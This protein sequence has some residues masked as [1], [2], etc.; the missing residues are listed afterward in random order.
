MKIW[1]R[2]GVLRKTSTYARTSGRATP[3]R[4]WVSAAR[5]S[6]SA[7]ASTMA[8]AEMRMVGP[9]L[10]GEDGLR[11]LAELDPVGLRHEL[12]HVPV[13]DGALDHGDSLPRDVLEPADR[14]RLGHEQERAGHEVRVRELDHL[15]ALVGNRHGRDDDVDLPRLEEGNA[16]AGGD[17]DQLDLVLVV[18]ERPREPMRDVDIEADVLP[19]G[20]DRAEGWE[21]G[22]H[23]CDQLAALLRDLERRLRFHPAGGAKHQ[24]EPER[25]STN[26]SSSRHV[27]ESHLPREEM[28]DIR[29]NMKS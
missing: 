13:L 26:E 16:V 7:T 27:H 29:W 15:A 24:R 10:D 17:R 12:G 19:G 1:I 23:A 20:V 2:S 14:R 11:D 21:V 4:T 18:E 5:T 6:P 3:P 22:L 8:W 28:E 9:A 25:H